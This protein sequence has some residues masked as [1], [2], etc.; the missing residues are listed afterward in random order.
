LNNSLT[1]AAHI[2][3]NISINSEPEA[4]KNGT[5]AS[6]ATALANNVFPD[7]GDQYNNTHLGILAH[8]FSYFFEFLR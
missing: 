2:P 8:A 7:Q 6:H 4:E 5:D 3:T 1:L